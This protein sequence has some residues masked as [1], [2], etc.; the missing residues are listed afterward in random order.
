MKASEI[1]RAPKCRFYHHHKHVPGERIQ[2]FAVEVLG[3]AVLS[4]EAAGEVEQYYVRT[5]KLYNGS[6]TRPTDVE[7]IYSLEEFTGSIVK[8]DV[9]VPRF[10]EIHD[11]EDIFELHKI[12]AELY[13][14]VIK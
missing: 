12:S 13:T 5:R 11:P 7:T 9:N 8:N 3:I 1:R 6:T 10:R 14:A 4:G 2:N